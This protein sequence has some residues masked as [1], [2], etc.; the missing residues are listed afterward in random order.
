MPL[1]KDYSLVI[2]Y[3]KHTENCVHDGGKFILR[4]SWLYAKMLQLSL[5]DTFII[6]METNA[7]KSK[8]HKIFK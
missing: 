6:T 5:G 7:E 2:Y 1:S 3:M 4:S 8:I